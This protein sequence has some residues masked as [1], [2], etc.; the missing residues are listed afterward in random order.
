M[1]DFTYD[2]HDLLITLIETEITETKSLYK[3]VGKNDKTELMEYVDE[4]T[5]CLEKLKKS[6]NSLNK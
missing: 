4:L 3:K 6:Q 5:V 2:E 1:V